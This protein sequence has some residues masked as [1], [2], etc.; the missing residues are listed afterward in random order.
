[1]IK[2]RNILQEILNEYNM[3]KRNKIDET[4]LTVKNTYEGETIE[5]KIRRITN[6]KEPIT[7]GAPQLYTDRKDGVK[8][9]YNIRTDR[10]ELA[11]DAMDIVSKTKLAQRENYLKAVKGD[12][13]PGNDVGGAEPTQAT[14]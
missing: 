13:A 5:Q 12:E 1:M 11:V 2:Q 9:E 6:N 7:D 3:Y 4:S 8:P 10:F 14:E